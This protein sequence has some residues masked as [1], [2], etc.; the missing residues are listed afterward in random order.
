MFLCNREGGKQQLV[1]VAAE[2][3]SKNM[4]PKELHQRMGGKTTYTSTIFIKVYDYAGLRWPITAGSSRMHLNAKSHLMK[5][6]RPV[7]FFFS[8]AAVCSSSQTSPRSEHEF[9][10]K[11]GVSS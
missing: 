7:L 8:V 6:T 2:Q 11:L 9:Y 5:S 1:F 10:T 4:N 3:S